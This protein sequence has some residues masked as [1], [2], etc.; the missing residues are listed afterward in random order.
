MKVLASRYVEAW[1]ATTREATAVI[2]AAAYLRDA[3]PHRLVARGETTDEIRHNL[4]SFVRGEESAA[5]L[6]G[7][8]QSGPSPHPPAGRAALTRGTVLHSDRGSQ[9]GLNRSLQH[10]LVEPIVGAR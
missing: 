8:A 1:P 10:R 2:S 4:E 9:T 3:L 5:V 7:Q 6:T